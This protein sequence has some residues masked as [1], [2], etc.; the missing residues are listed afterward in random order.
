MTSAGPADAART[1]SDSHHPALLPGERRM[2]RLLYL[3]YG[4]RGITDEQGWRALSA[5][6]LCTERQESSFP[7]S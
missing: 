2:I 1:L 6:R 5:L 7:F 3:S 4:T